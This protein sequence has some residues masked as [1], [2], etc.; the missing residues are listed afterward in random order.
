METIRVSRHHDGVVAEIMLNRPEAM[1][2]ISSELAAQLTRTCAELAEAAEVRA[3][4][5]SAAGE[6]AFCAGV[7]L[8]ER[9]GMTD[10]DLIRQRH[11]IRAEDGRRRGARLCPRRWL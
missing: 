7:D 6:R 1:N 11:A 3:V 5:L 2:S 8:K 9:A 4:V 10:A